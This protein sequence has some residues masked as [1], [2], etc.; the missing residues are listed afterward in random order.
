MTWANQTRILVENFKAL[1]T[2][3][4]GT[5]INVFKP[6]VIAINGAMGSLMTFVKAVSSSLGKILGWQYEDGSGGLANDFESS[7]DFADDLADS[8]DKTSKNIDKMKKGLR[9]FDELKTISLE[10]GDSDKGSKGS[11]AKGNGAGIGAGTG[12]QWTKVDSIFKNYESELD[13]F[14]KLGEYIAEAITNGIASF[15]AGKFAQKLSNFASGI[16]QFFTGFFEGLVNNETFNVIGQHI[17]D[18]I[19]GIDYARLIWDA[20]NLLSG[21][22]NA[23]INA[24]ADLFEGIAENLIS[25]IFGKDVDLGSY[26]PLQQKFGEAIAN[27]FMGD[28]LNFDGVFNFDFTKQLLRQAE[29]SFGNMA[30][31][32]QNGNVGDAL[33]E[34]FNG[35][36]SSV[37]SALVFPFEPLADALS[38]LW[39][40]AKKWWTTNAKLPKIKSPMIDDIVNTLST[41]WSKAKKWWSSK[42]SL[43]KISVS[44]PDIKKTAQSAWNSLKSWWN[45]NVK[46]KIPKLNFQV[47]YKEPSGTIQKAVVKAL[48]LKGWPSLQ[49]FATGGFPEDGTFRASH[50]EIMG[51]FDNGQSVVANNKQITDG[52][53]AAVY[54]GNKENNA[55]LR[56]ELELMRTQNELLSRI[57][58]KE[59]GISS[60]D[61]FNSVRQSAREYNRMTG[62]PAFI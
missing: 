6:L 2:V 51:R 34:A 61:L 18:F 11:G 3:I 39:A 36:L 13:S 44:F 52:I 56:Q 4:G 41:A 27:I 37:A 42:G 43:S 25:R 62:N 33:V 5:L 14:R 54:Q 28:G 32:F 59:T 60:R 17:V 15:D 50:G 49:F 29:T 7:A 48:S 12:G 9:A 58:E 46:L 10:T 8:T 45:K 55:L 20:G 26:K 40:N 16:M 38:D 23:V 31:A 19:C 21:F 53:S 1:A 47:S 30:R 57:L 24:P 22:A 35:V